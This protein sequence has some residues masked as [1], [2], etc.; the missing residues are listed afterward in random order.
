[1]HLGSS[2]TVGDAYYAHPA[3]IINSGFKDATG[4]IINLYDYISSLTSRISALEETINL[5]KGVLEVYLVRSGNQTRLF[6][7]NSLNFTLNIEDYLVAT[8]VGLLSYPQDFGART[9]RNDLLLISD[10]QILV[11][12]SST[13]ADLGLLSNRGYGTPLGLNPSQFAYDGANANGTTRGL[14]PLWLQSDGS[15][16]KSRRC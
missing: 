7:G 11:L 3:N 8:K 13:T 14:Q 9:Y 10:F 4:N 1:M 12:N 6:S 16:F 5:A 2:V 15:F